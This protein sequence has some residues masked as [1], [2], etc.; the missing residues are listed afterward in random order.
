[1]QKCAESF[2][3]QNY[4]DWQSKFTSN[5]LLNFKTVPVRWKSILGSQMS[6]KLQSILKKELQR[7]VEDVIANISPN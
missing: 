6:T 2:L 4:L 1:M 5:G 7:Q 3:K